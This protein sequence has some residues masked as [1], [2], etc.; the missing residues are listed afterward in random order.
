MLC[1]PEVMSHG[2]VWAVVMQ[3][4]GGW[5]YSMHLRFKAPLKLVS[6]LWNRN[7]DFDSTYNRQN[8]YEYNK[9]SKDIK[10]NLF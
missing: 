5:L 7:V 9:E 2:Y 1:K 8:V 10:G 6:N 4:H 3:G